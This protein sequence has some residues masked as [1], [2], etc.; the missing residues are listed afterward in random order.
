MSKS[1]PL[2]AGSTGLT[3]TC[4]VSEA[5]E[6]LTNMPSALWLKDTL[7][8][9]G[10]ESISLTETSRNDTTAVT[11]LSFFPLKT[12]HAG[13]YTCQGMLESVAAT[14]GTII[15]STQPV[16]VN[17]SCEYRVTV[18]R[19]CFCV[20]YDAVP[21][22]D[23][24][25]SIPS[26]PLYEG[27]S[28]TLTCTITLLSPVDTDVIINIL[29]QPDLYNER[30]STVSPS[31][32]R[33]PFTFTLTFNP[34]VMSDGG[35]YSCRATATSSYPYINSSSEKR[36][37]RKILTINGMYMQYSSTLGVQAQRGLQYL[38]CVSV[39][40]SVTALGVDRLFQ[41]ATNGI[42]GILLGFLGFKCPIHV[43]C[44]FICSALPPPTVSISVSGNSSAGQQ[45]T[46]N[47]SA[48]VV[49]GLISNP[50]MKI[51][52]PNST[53]VADMDTTSVQYTFSPL[54]TSDGGQYNCTATINIPKAGIAN[55][56]TSKLKT[57]TVSSQF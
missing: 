42:Y 56:N 34:L 28:Q 39:Y 4:T 29:W 27:T 24:A 2:E 17:V 46:I 12:S 8:V 14:N 20:F 23:V 31:S 21:T 48:T 37:I 41:P 36:S 3:L 11:T 19:M 18:C 9:Q 51:V 43:V 32:Q 47:C 5:I 54:R 38:V 6:G 16:S 1:G 35:P 15:N 10:S 49:A 33:S 44:F 26:G 40:L 7:V 55:L 30:V 57:V 53:L 25:L 52:S 13:Q 45:Y 22:P 50:D